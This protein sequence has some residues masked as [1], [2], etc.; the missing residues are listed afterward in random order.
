MPLHYTLHSGDFVE[1][2]TSKAGR[3]PSR[4]WM[5]SRGLVARPQQDPPV[6]LARDA[7]GRRAEGPRRARAGAEG[8]EPAVPQARGLAAARAGDPR[9][10]LQEGRGLLRRDR[11]GEAPVRPDRQQGAPAPQDER[12]RPGAGRPAQRRRPATPC[13]AA[14]SGSTCTGS[15]TSSS[16]WPSAARRCRATRSSATSRSGKGI[17]V[18]RED[19]PN[20]RALMR[21][22]ERFTPVDWDGD[23][24]TEL[25]RRDRRR[26]LGPAAPARGRGAHLLR[27][28]RQHRLV[29]RHRR[30][31]AGQELVRGRARRRQVDARRC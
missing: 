12:G 1:I 22:P 18:H 28:R 2:L 27:A 14:S 5:A 8:P 25:P 17:T 11:L 13:R 23:A 21:N 31:S 29:R 4:D 15:R 19:C 3:G 16:G 9:D 30:G 6:V 7:R 26:R 10:R 24:S 20:V